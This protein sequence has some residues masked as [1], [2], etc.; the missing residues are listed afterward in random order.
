MNIFFST[1]LNM[2]LDAQKNRLTEKVLL[3]F[4]LSTRKNA[5]VYAPLSRGHV[6]WSFTN[7]ILSIYLNR[8]IIQIQTK[9]NQRIYVPRNL[10]FVY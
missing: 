7:Y 8:Y 4:W 2:C 6:T 3:M 5:F 1:S 10:M 9:R